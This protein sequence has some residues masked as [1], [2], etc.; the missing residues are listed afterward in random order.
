VLAVDLAHQVVVDVRLP[1]HLGS[2][3]SFS[4]GDFS[5]LLLGSHAVSAD[6][7]AWTWMPLD[8]LTAGWGW[9]GEYIYRL[10]VCLCGRT[11]KTLLFHF[12]F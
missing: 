1:R 5:R 2:S 6:A 10:R 8:A 4:G 7:F 12:A 9:G 3:S 11:W